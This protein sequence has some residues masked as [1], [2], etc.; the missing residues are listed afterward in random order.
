M[1]PASPVV[2]QWTGHSVRGAQTTRARE[3]EAAGAKTDKHYLEGTARI[4]V[5]LSHY[6]GSAAAA[7]S[8]VQWIRAAAS[9]RTNT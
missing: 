4:I 2:R 9:A 8:A 1:S 7:R 3:V 5:L 6:L